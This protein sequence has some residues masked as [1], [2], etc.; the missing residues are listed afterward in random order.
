MIKRII[1]HATALVDRDKRIVKWSKGRFTQANVGDVLNEYLFPKVF[2]KEPVNIG[3]VINPGFPIV[4]SFIGSTLDNNSV[5]SLVVLG[6]G[7]KSASSNLPEKPKKVV[8]CRGPLTRKKLIEAGL[9][10]PETYG[11]PAILLPRYYQPK[12]SKMYRMGIIPHYVDKD[13]K[14]LENWRNK[15]GVKIIDVSSGVEDFVEDI[16]SC[17][18][19]ISSSLHGVIISHAYGIPSGWV[20][21]S[22]RLAGGAFKFQDYFNSVGVEYDPI[23]L[24]DFSH[25]GAFQKKAILPIDKL[26][27]RAIELAEKFRFLKI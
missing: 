24:D 23:L 19:T 21:L 12:S 1:K 18:F 2:D 5:K 3:E 16:N 17:D 11:D 13:V 14:E 27:E 8:A 7:F 25:I 10:V 4:Y 15:P 6:S 20:K 9:D 26:E 22:E